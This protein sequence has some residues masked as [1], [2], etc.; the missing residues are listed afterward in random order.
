MRVARVQEGL[1]PAR[2]GQTDPDRVDAERLDPRQ[3]ALDVGDEEVEV[4]RARATSGQEAVEER[5]VRTPG[6]CQQL[7]LRAGGE[8]QLTPP[9]PGGVTAI[10]PGSA[11]NAAEQLPAI[12][13]GRRAD[14]EVIE[15]SGHEISRYGQRR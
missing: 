15:D 5:R 13:Q 14:G 3:R 4:V 6:G 8:Y 7:D 2:I 1:S 9:E 10:R 11:E 12:R